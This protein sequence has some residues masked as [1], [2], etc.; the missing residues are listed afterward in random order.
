[1]NPNILN[2]TDTEEITMTLPSG[3]GHEDFAGEKPQLISKGNSVFA[4]L[5]LSAQ[6]DFQE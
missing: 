2:N 5:I 6:Q 4:R 1:M 3:F